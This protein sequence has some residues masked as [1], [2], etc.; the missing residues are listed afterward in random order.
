MGADSTLVNA[1]FKEA[2]S[3]AGATAINMKPLYD[4]GVSNMN[5]ALDKIN[6]AMGLYSAKKEANR[7]GVRKQM[8]EFQTQSNALVKGMY[9]QDEPMHSAFINAFRKRITDL[10]D[11][12][13]DVNTYGKGDNQENSNARARIMGEL[14]RVQN[15]ATNFRA[16]TEIFFNNLKDVD[17]GRVYGP[18]VAAHQQ[19]LNFKDYDTL[20]AEGKIKVQYGKN[21]IE[22]IS[23]GYTTKEE[24]NKLFITGD[25]A[26]PI[27]VTLDSLNQNFPLTNTAHHTEITKVINNNIERGVAKG[28][29]AKIAF[30]SNGEM[31]EMDYDLEASNAAF[32]RLV[33]TEENFRNVVDS[34]IDGLYEVETSFRSSL[35]NELSIPIAVLEN[36]IID[37]NN[38]GINDIE[39]IF[40]FLDRENDGIITAED[41]AKGEG[42]P[43]FEQNLDSLIDAL[44][45][46][47]H[48]AFNMKTSAPMLGAFL[49]KISKGR[50]E[51]AFNSTAGSRKKDDGKTG[52]YIVNGREMNSETFETSYGSTVRMINNPQEGDVGTGRTGSGKDA[53]TRNFIYKNG[54][55]FTETPGGT[56]GVYNKETTAYNMAV[57]TGLINYTNVKAP[58]LN[59]DD[60]EVEELVE[61]EVPNSADFAAI[62]SPKKIL[63]SWKKR[64]EGKGFKYDTSGGGTVVTITADNGE[65]HVAK[66]ATLRGNRNDQAKALNEFIEKNKI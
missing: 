60:V 23:S 57:E 53:I 43:V 28:T 11:E 8:A 47:D 34:T 31:L 36:M 63:A 7:V 55:Y 42:N 52:N 64:Y 48:P 65:T 15:Q 25:M 12:F 61:V 35:E 46:T 66:L 21:G 33:N 18:S 50:E 1:A 38:N 2:T 41:V 44:T 51:R 62:V 22:I 13:E 54:K 19:A 26:K 20:I 16:G 30:N 37:D 14:Q 39:E 45:N 24:D 29:D 32:T 27:T 58:D 9:A 56:P 49:A 6:N 3:R 5:K 4:S 40:T 17:S 10:Q 59:L